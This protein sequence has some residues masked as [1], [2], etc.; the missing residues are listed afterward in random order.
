MFLIEYFSNNIPS[1]LLLQ[2]AFYK[3]FLI[4]KVALPKNDTRNFCL[5][6]HFQSYNGKIKFSFLQTVQSRGNTSYLQTSH[7]CVKCQYR[8]LVLIFLYTL[9]KI[10]WKN[11]VRFWKWD[12]KRTPQLAQNSFSRKSNIKF[13]II[14][15]MISFPSTQGSGKIRLGCSN[16][17]LLINYFDRRL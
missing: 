6:F 14:F 8:F 15:N 7:F 4:S 1:V 11:Y 12:L 5:F 3:H 10:L 16:V 17:L 2:N 13:C 9:K